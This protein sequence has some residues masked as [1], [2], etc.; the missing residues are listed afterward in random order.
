[1]ELLVSPLPEGA[2]REGVLYP[3]GAHITDL[4]E[5]RGLLYKMQRPA[6]APSVSC[7]FNVTNSTDQMDYSLACLSSRLVSLFIHALRFLG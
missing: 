3:D 7:T 5:A 2:S 4:K 6:I 1:M